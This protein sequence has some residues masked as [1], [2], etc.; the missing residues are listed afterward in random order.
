M[1]K[2]LYMQIKK[3]KDPKQAQPFRLLTDEERGVLLKAGPSQCL[4]LC[5]SGSW[6]DKPSGPYSF[7]YAYIL[8]PDYQPEPEYEKFEVFMCGGILG[9]D[10]PT[11][12]PL[13]T[14]P[15][16]PDFVGFEFIDGSVTT[17][18]LSL[19]DVANDFRRGKTVCARFIKEG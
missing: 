7:C 8:K 6:E 18:H 17:S 19:V 9:I 4:I 12:K 2:A 1:D 5:E 15:G 11:F 14:L 16:L 10:R 3:L 13:Y